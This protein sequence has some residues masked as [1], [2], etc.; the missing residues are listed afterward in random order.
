MKSVLLGNA[1]ACGTA[2]PALRFFQDKMKTKLKVIGKTKGIPSTLFATH[3]R[4]SDSERKKLLQQIATWPETEEGKGM[5]KA[6]KVEK[7]VTIEDK[8]YD[9][10]RKMSKRFR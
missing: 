5:L 10:V 1:Q 6:T 8:A 9:G 7:F 2:A 4:V 3:P